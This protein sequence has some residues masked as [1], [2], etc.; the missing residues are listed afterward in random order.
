MKIFLIGFMG[1][2]KTTVGQNLAIALR[3][4]FIDIDQ[5]IALRENRTIAEIFSQSGESYFRQLESNYLQGIVD[6]A[7]YATGGGIVCN[8]SN[9]SILTLISDLIIWLNPDWTIIYDRIVDSDRP[10]VT[11]KKAHQLRELYDT[12]QPL[13]KAIADIEFRGS[14]LNALIM[15]IKKARH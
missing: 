12:R 1:A 10:I 4:P 11:S 2:G 3:L 13:Y 7:V 8:P 6:D 9:C 14:D 15:S 5:Q